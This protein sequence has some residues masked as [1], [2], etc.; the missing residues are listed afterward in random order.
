[1]EPLSITQEIRNKVVELN[2]LIE[3]AYYLDNIDVLI[4]Q[5]DGKAYVAAKG[6]SVD[7]ARLISAK[8]VTS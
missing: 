6:H 8:F 7:T 1:M 4:K 5:G 3:E 2:K